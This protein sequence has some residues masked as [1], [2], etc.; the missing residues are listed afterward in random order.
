MISKPRPRGSG[1][2]SCQCLERFTIVMRDSRTT[3]TTLAINKWGGTF[4]AMLLLFMALWVVWRISVLGLRSIHTHKPQR[5][6]RGLKVPPNFN[7][8]C[9]VTTISTPA[10]QTLIAIVS[11]VPGLKKATSTCERAIPPEVKSPKMVHPDFP[12][13]RSPEHSHNRGITSKI[14]HDL[15]RL[16]LPSCPYVPHYEQRL[17]LSWNPS[18]IE[19][20][21]GQSVQL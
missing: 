16:L 19:V 13:V 6:Q 11:A 7:S 21:E 17:T 15:Y 10:S 20:T 3:K 4:K 12:E 5:Q 18:F 9:Y 14:G 1:V 2:D 8:V